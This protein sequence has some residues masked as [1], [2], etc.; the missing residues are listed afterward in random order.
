LTASLW[1]VDCV[2]SRPGDELTC[3][4]WRVDCVTSWPGDEL[5]VWRVDWQP[6]DRHFEQPKLLPTNTRFWDQNNENIWKMWVIV[7][8]TSGGENHHFRHFGISRGAC[9]QIPM[10]SDFGS[11]LPDVVISHTREQLTAV[12]DFQP[13]L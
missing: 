11:M 9:S 10:L 1:R 12:A 4:D 13:C 7:T 3:G 2:T 8:D 6:S 5:T